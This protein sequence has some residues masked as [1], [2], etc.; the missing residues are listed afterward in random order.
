L[1][2]VEIHHMYSGVVELTLYGWDGVVWVEIF[3]RPAPDFPIN[4]PANRTTWYPRSYVISSEHTRY[5]V[6]FYGQLSEPND[7]WKFS[8]VDVSVS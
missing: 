3:F 6:E 8:C 7:G 2:T 1:S 5:K 4:T